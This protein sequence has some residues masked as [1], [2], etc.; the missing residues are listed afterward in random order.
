VVAFDLSPQQFLF[1]LFNFFNSSNF[2]LHFSIF[3]QS[4]NAQR[5]TNN[6]TTVSKTTTF[7]PPKPTTHAPQP[8]EN[9][10]FRAQRTY[11][12]RTSPEITAKKVRL[13][14]NFVASNQKCSN[15]L[16]ELFGTTGV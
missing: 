12:F 8:T 13:K 14:A 16:A 2:K 15:R 11:G 4:H 3:N 9:I 1:Q 6:Q 5:T 7:E 10:A